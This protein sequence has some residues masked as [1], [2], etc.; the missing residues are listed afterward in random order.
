MR[1]RHA[2]L[3]SA[4]W[5]N[6]F[7]SSLFNIKHINPNRKGCSRCSPI[8]PPWK[9]AARS[10][11][12]SISCVVTRAAQM[13][14]NAFSGIRQMHFYD[15]IFEKD[16]IV[17]YHFISCFSRWCALSGY[18]NAP[19]PIM[20]WERKSLRFDHRISLS[21]SKQKSR[22]N[23][24]LTIFHV[25]MIGSKVL[26]QFASSRLLSSLYSLSISVPPGL[27]FPLHSIT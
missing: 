27:R 25:I 10:W 5:S 7:S 4:G 14:P 3:R 24:L 6:V 11:Q 18:F 20:R 13:S 1:V 19:R 8:I 9:K 15:I 23:Y 2:R 26:A 21:L 16:S 12:P 17:K 22:N